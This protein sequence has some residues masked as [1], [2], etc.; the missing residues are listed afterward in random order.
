MVVADVATKGGDALLFN[1]NSMVEQL[2][3]YGELDA[4]IQPAHSQ[5]KGKF[6]TL[7]CPGNEVGYRLRPDGY[8]E[9]FKTLTLQWPAAIIVLGCGMNKS[10]AGTAGLRYFQAQLRTEDS[11]LSVATMPSFLLTELGLPYPDRIHSATA[12]FYRD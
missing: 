3:A 6:R 9:P 12:N 7:A 8:A 10:F 4:Y 2:L 5:K 1:G 11:R